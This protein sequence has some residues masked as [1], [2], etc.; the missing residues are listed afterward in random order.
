MSINDKRNTDPISPYL[1]RVS[2]DMIGPNVIQYMMANDVVDESNYY[3][4]ILNMLN[5]SGASGDALRIALSSPGISAGNT[6]A[7]DIQLTFAGHLQDLGDVDRS[8]SLAQVGTA[9]VDMGHILVFSN[10]QD[11]YI[12]RQVTGHASLGTGGVLTLSE[13]SVGVTNLNLTQDGGSG[14]ILF[15]T[16]TGG[17]LAF[18]QPYLTHLTDVTTSGG[19][20]GQMLVYGDNSSFH[21]KTISGDVTIAQTGVVTIVDNAVGLAELDILNSEAVDQLILGVSGSGATAELKYYTRTIDAGEVTGPE[22]GQT[23]I[24]IHD[25][26][27][28]RFHTGI[29]IPDLGPTIG[30][31]T[32]GIV[33]P[34]G[35]ASHNQMLGVV[36]TG[37]VL[38]WSWLNPIDIGTGATG[39]GQLQE[40][41][42]TPGGTAPGV[43]R[44]HIFIGSDQ[45]TL[46]N[47]PITGD[48]T[49]TPPSTG[50]AGVTL[51]VTNISGLAPMI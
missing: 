47:L 44:S 34:V 19:T 27:Q 22:A 10:E 33:G 32:T 42:F 24:L 50:D 12:T 14:S 9:G 17:K 20:V 15:Q 4:Q 26:Y 5:A 31:D 1:R 11:K 16:N 2:D 8:A 48:I 25:G 46:I 23:A 41:S 6:A 21:N 39:I 30:S 43:P 49:V 36:Q 28:P 45:G 18:F 37:G 38:R 13:D 7:T 51:S 35:A 40:V 29:E 3:P